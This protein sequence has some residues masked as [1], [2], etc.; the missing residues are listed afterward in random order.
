M[1]KTL[2]ALAVASACVASAAQADTSNVVIYGQ[3][4]ASVDLVKQSDSTGASN[5]TSRTK[6][7]SNQSRI[8]FKGM[9]DLG[10]GMSANFQLEEGFNIDGNKA[11]TTNLLTGDTMV[12]RNSY[13]GL[14]GKSWGEFRL[15]RHDA[16]YKIATRSLDNF[17]DTLADN[18]NIFLGDVR[19]ND[20]IAYMTPNMSGFQALVA[21]VAGAEKAAHSGTKGDAWDLAGIYANG[22]IYASLA[23]DRMKMGTA[24]TG[25]ITTGSAAN[26]GKSTKAWKLG[27]G[28]NFGEA[29][30][31]F[32]Y[33]HISDDFVTGTGND[34]NSWTLNG[35]Y[36]M[37]SNV[38]KAA[39][40]K[41][42]KV[43]NVDQTGAKLV[44]IGIDHNLSK[45][46]SVYALYTKLT[47]DSAVGYDLGGYSTATTGASS[48]LAGSD[49]SAWSFGIKHSF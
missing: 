32:V 27:V 6:V 16:P 43:D 13:V 17:A 4:N 23:Y 46:T 7:S 47:N 19:V 40:T 18:R 25:S 44:A 31:G 5:D 15:G 21:Y 48:V 1:K 8:G 14:S 34:R 49:P 36:K 37:G 9:E 22:P 30:V 28:Y 39:Y 38:L 10:N 45:R 35:S 11:G 29:N 26:V 24:G 42:G 41:A 12:S 2:I 33:E 20:M 3:A